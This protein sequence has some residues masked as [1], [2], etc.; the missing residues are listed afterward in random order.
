MMWIT[1][2][3]VWIWHRN[4][5][6][7]H[8]S[9]DKL[10]HSPLR[11]QHKLRLNRGQATMLGN[12]D[13]HCCHCCIIHWLCV[14][15]YVLNVWSYSLTSH[16]IH[17]NWLNILTKYF[18]NLPV[19]SVPSICNKEELVLTMINTN[20]YSKKN[21]LLWLCYFTHSAHYALE[22]VSR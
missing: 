8:V 14:S 20:S 3:Q 22:I 7:T 2:T 18:S 12:T 16:N 17:D 13:T 1:S 19:A 11:L 10:H 15:L 21:I 6:T 9:F 5:L 4:Q